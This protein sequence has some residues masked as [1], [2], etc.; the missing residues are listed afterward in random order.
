M[1]TEEQKEQNYSIELIEFKFSQQRTKI[2]KMLDLY[3]DSQNKVI[4]TKKYFA[5]VM[6][7]LE[8]ITSMYFC[9]QNDVTRQK[10]KRTDPAV[11]KRMQ[12]YFSIVFSDDHGESYFTKQLFKEGLLEFF[13]EQKPIQRVL[14]V[15]EL[16]VAASKDT[17]FE[18]FKSKEEGSGMPV[19]QELPLDDPQRA[20]IERTKTQYIELLESGKIKDMKR[21]ATITKQIGELDRQ[22]E[23]LD[24][25]KELGVKQKKKGGRTSP[26]GAVKMDTKNTFGGDTSIFSGT[27]PNVKRFRTLKKAPVKKK[28]P[29]EQRAAAIREIFEFYSRQHIQRNIGFD[30]FQDSLKKI[31]LGEFNGMVRDFDIDIP[32]QKITEIFRQTAVNQ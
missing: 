25:A 3:V 29:A 12:D 23:E 9:Y 21:K 6:E 7:L 13:K 28:T 15:N 18:I 1:L 5:E 14:N 16:V 8:A 11:I 32:K 30:E 22:L 10:K 2:D 31:D 19:E 17:S 24:L 27:S 4:G 26:R 20:Q